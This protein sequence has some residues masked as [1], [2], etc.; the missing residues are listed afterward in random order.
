MRRMQAHLHFAKTASRQKLPLCMIAPSENRLETRTS[1]R[2]WSPPYAKYALVPTVQNF[3]RYSYVFNNP[4]SFTDPTGYSAWTK[5]RRPVVGA[6][7]AIA[8]YGAASAYMTGAAMSGGASTSF[9]SVAVSSEAGGIIGASLTGAGQV[10]AASAAGFASGGIMGGNI[11]SAVQGAFSAGITAGVNVAVAG[12]DLAVQVTAKAATSA[13][14][15]YVQGGDWRRAAYFSA[16]STLGKAG[17]EYTREQTDHLYESACNR[18]GA[19]TCKYDEYGPQTDGGREVARGISRGEDGEWNRVP[20]LIRSYLDGGMAKE[21]DPHRYTPGQGFCNAIGSSLCGAIRG[22][23][24]Q[25]SKPHDWGNSWGYEKD[26]LS[27]NLGYRVEGGGFS[28]LG[29]RVAYEMGVQTWSFATMPV[30][31]GFTGFSLYGDYFNPNVY[32]RGRR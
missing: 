32:G 19:G 30:M 8:T 27:T 12:A 29:A 7:I 10:V 21:G 23:V 9:A 20:R 15:A 6:L 2:V 25:V 28:S 24:R 22:F 1:A 16:F 11:Q 26:A 5:W 14:L 4:L 18:V 3:N 17:W 13:A 31:A